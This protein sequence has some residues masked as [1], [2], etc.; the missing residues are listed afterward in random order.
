MNTFDLIRNG[1]DRNI[2]VYDA[3]E[4]EKLSLRIFSL[5]KV[6]ARRNSIKIDRFIVDLE[7]Q[8]EM[9]LWYPELNSLYGMPKVSDLDNL[10][11]LGLPVIFENGLTDFNK[12]PYI[13]YYKDLGGSFMHGY[14]HPGLIIAAGE[15]CA[16]LGCYND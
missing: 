10:H 11:L 14:N 15:D 16:L 2:L 3:K 8:I 13:L 9:N 5:L 4:K 6:V 7:C 1:L 12:V